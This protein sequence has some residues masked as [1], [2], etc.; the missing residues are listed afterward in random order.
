MFTVIDQTLCLEK[1]KLA[2]ALKNYKIL[3]RCTFLCFS[4]FWFDFQC[5]ACCT[6]H[7][8]SA[9]VIKQA[10]FME[11]SLWS[12]TS[13]AAH[14]W[15]TNRVHPVSIAIGAIASWVFLLTPS[16]WVIWALGVLDSFLVL[17]R[18]R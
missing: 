13:K 7:G 9:H 17:W 10:C 11:D 3:R 16:F 6:V 15:V 8:L 4:T 14:I 12:G 18:H 1:A 2:Y 5:F